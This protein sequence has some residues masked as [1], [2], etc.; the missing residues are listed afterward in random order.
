M[1]HMPLSL[2]TIVVPKVNEWITLFFASDFHIGS[3]FV[4]YAKIKKD[5]DEA[6]QRNAR[7][8]LVGDI[9]DCVVQGDTKRF[10]PHGLDPR[11]AK[12]PASIN[13]AVDIAV[14]LFKPYANLIDCIGIGNHEWQLMHRC[15]VNPVRSMIDAL[16]KTDGVAIKYTGY[17]W[18][19]KYKIVRGNYEGRRGGIPLVVYYHHGCGADAP[20]THGIMD[21]SRA[22][23]GNVYDLFVFGHR[24]K[25]FAMADTY[26]YVNSQDRIVSRKRLALQTG[27]YMV[28]RSLSDV[29]NPDTMDYA[30]RVTYKSSILGGKFVKAKL[31]G[32][33]GRDLEIIAEV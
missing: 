9:F 15:N 14:E 27:S 16:N 21:A 20:I 19:Q 24:H 25:S 13:A 32:D 22:A 6:K 3:S 2:N 18:F 1:H 8:N 23:V 30:T 26:C 17:T 11:I 28:G 29:G 33:G 7:I 4:D 10:D 12:S 5:L 31:V